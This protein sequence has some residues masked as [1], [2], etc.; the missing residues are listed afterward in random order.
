M[1]DDILEKL[2]AETQQQRFEARFS[3]VENGP[4]VHPFHT[5]AKQAEVAVCANCFYWNLGTFAAHA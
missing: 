2:G 3:K 4:A 1:P 5:L